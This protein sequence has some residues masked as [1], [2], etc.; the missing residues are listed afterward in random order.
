MTI[1]EFKNII[2]KENDQIVV[3]TSGNE[4]IY[5][6]DKDKMK[7]LGWICGTEP[8]HFTIYS[9]LSDRK[10]WNAVNRFSETLPNER[11]LLQQVN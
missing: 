4:D 5:V 10:S 1:K 2:S 7:V 9:G 3:T 11:G 6:I 8:D